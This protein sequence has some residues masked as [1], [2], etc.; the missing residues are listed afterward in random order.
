MPA[1]L[2]DNKPSVCPFGHELVPGCIQVG[3]TPCICEPAREAASRSRGMGHVVLHCRVCE[4]EG[5]TAVFYEPA[6]DTKQWHVR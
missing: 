4:A 6:H 1:S 2:F 5:R 3:W